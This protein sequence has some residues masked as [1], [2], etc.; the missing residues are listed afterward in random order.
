MLDFLID[1]PGP[2]YVFLVLAIVVAVALWWRTDRKWFLLGGIVSLLLIVALWLLGRWIETD[3]LQ[4]ERRIREMR[5][6]VQ[7]R[8]VDQILANISDKFH[9]GNYNKAQ[10]RTRAAEALR[11]LDINDIEVWD[12]RE[13][14]TAR[15]KREASV[16]FSVKPHTGFSRGEFYKCTAD[17]VLDP[18]GQW[19]MSGFRVFNPFVDTKTPL[20]IPEL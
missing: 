10:F 11:R 8:N 2:I 5:T 7:Q 13:H 6:G 19:R 14:Q 12:F 9:F 15:E 3:N 18:D 4:I 16:T 20:D 17:F 1:E